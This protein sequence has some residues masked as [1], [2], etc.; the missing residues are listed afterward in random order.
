MFSKQC[1]LVMS[2]GW[3]LGKDDRDWVK[4]CMTLEV[5]GIR[6]RRRPKKTWWARVKDDMESLG[7]SQMDIQ[8][9]SK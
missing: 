1:N 9:S 7:L 6:Q 2:K 5:E 3:V 8:F 4:H